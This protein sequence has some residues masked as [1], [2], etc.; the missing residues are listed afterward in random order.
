M[1]AQERWDAIVVGAGALGCATAY[2]L[3]TRGAT[4]V[5]VLEQY[6]FGHPHGASEDHSRIIRHA[7]HD[8]AY[9]EL[10]QAAYDGWAALEERSGLALV[11]RTGGLDL[12]AATGPGTDE[13]ARYRA[14]LEHTGHEYADLDAA[15][16][17]R[18]WPQWQID[19]DTIGLFQ[20]DGGLLDIRRAA[21]THAAL[22]RA[23]GVE[24]R[25]HSPVRSVLPSGESVEVTVPGET[26]IADRV[27]LCTASWT[28]RLLE[29]L[30]AALPLTLSQEQVCYFATPNVRE[31]APDRFPI[32]LWHG[33][34]QLYYGFPSTARWRSGGPRHEWSLR[35][36]RNSRGRARPDRD[37][38]GARLPRHASAPSARP[39]ADE[40]HLRVRHAAGP[41]LRPRPASWAPADHDRH[42]RGG[43]PRSSPT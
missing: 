39:A 29:P 6:A 3:A 32:W 35:D 7:Y 21:A 33:D 19:D 43:T 42:R 1:T 18:R 28:G 41:K 34:P 20:A 16:I 5:L 25:T 38:T 23:D 8:L 2:W 36:A 27:V 26:L 22:A 13:L 12:A 4:R 10:T 30:D 31:F 17:R 37:R 15:E 14:S 40:S 9:A 11:V 24:I